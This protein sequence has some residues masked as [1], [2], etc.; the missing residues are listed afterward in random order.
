MCKPPRY[1]VDFT[2]PLLKDGINLHSRTHPWH[3]EMYIHW[4]A[5]YLHTN[6]IPLSITQV[7][8]LK[9]FR[10]SAEELISCCSEWYVFEKHWLEGIDNHICQNKSFQDFKDY[11]EPYWRETN[12]E[13]SST[14]E[15]WSIDEYLNISESDYNDR[16]LEFQ[17]LGNC[18]FEFQFPD[19]PFRSLLSN[20][21]SKVSSQA[22][23]YIMIENFFKAFTKI[24]IKQE[25]PGNFLS[26][27]KKSTHEFTCRTDLLVK[28]RI[29]INIKPQSL[30]KI[31]KLPL[32][33]VIGEVDTSSQLPHENDRVV[34]LIPMV[35]TYECR[36]FDL[37]TVCMLVK[38]TNHILNHVAFYMPN[39]LEKNLDCKGQQYVALEGTVSNSTIFLD[40]LADFQVRRN[41]EDFGVELLEFSL[42]MEDLWF[43]QNTLPEL[44]VQTREAEALCFLLFAE[45]DS[46]EIMQK[47]AEDLVKINPE[48][49]EEMYVK[50]NLNK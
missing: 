31:G 39:E 11:L 33:Y 19:I 48:Y 41:H 38:E 12:A 22:M 42:G 36:H 24:I 15:L 29:F 2:L 4:L 10:G 50:S 16:I 46:A 21:V 3:W 45:S 1:S 18:V 43:S 5:D 28:D 44:F 14:D 26:R 27:I 49:A 37:L 34:I 9:N 32:F 40:K 25:Y 23:R 20:A 17:Q 7:N 13:C 30:F 47:C 35:E 8:W 6:E